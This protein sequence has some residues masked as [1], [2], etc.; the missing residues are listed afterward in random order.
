MRLSNIYNHIG[1]TLRDHKIDVAGNLN[2]EHL[3][4]PALE[5]IKA[6][7]LTCE[8]SLNIYNL[9]AQY[10]C[11]Q[12]VMI[13]GQIAHASK[14]MSYQEKP[15][16]LMEQIQRNSGNFMAHVYLMRM[17]NLKDMDL[18]PL[19]IPDIP[20]QKRA[21]F[22]LAW[23]A[24]YCTDENREGLEQYLA[25]DEKPS[26][27]RH[28]NMANQIRNYC[29]GLFEIQQRLLERRKSINAI[30]HDKGFIFHDNGEV[31][32]MDFDLWAAR[33][34][35][36]AEYDQISEKVD[37]MVYSYDEIMAGVG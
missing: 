6:I 18:Y 35:Y 20:V 19:C 10:V 12:E 2:Q 27:A 14:S 4:E 23:G 25:Q 30:Y 24:T 7:G 9:F 1:Q 31:E 29:G 16:R 21:E 5:N 32:L 3:T 11:R 17:F 15:D 13:I 8:E 22:I 36:K 37:A 28:F 33:E 34:G 26:F